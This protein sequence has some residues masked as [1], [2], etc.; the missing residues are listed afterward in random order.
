M[1][2]QK[3]NKLTDFLKRVALFVISFFFISSVFYAQDCYEEEPGCTEC[4]DPPKLQGGGDIVGSEDGDIFINGQPCNRVGMS[5]NYNCG[6]VGVDL[7]EDDFVID[8]GNCSWTIIE[9]DWDCPQEGAV[10]PITL[11]SFDVTH[12]FGVNIIEWV[13]A[14]ETNNWYFTLENS[15]DG[16]NWEFLAQIEGAGNSSSPKTYTFRHEDFDTGL[17]NYYRLKQ[18]DYDGAN[19]TFKP[20]AIDNEK[21]KSIV[22]KVNLMGQEVN[23]LNNKNGII[24]ILYSDGSSQ[25]FYQNK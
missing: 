20:V 9:G 8:D 10:L 16:I 2:E 5:S 18:M 25:K 6:G 17:I 14:T 3:K 24:V 21:N 13:T 1:N 23:D 22:K 4:C 15:N 19:K 11:V 7:E 12:E